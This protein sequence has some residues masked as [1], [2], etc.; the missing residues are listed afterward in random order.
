MPHSNDAGSVVCAVLIYY[1]KQ[2]MIL[3]SE[4]QGDN[5]GY[6][7]KTQTESKTT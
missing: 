6:A 4:E 5:I 3:E 2:R 1:F 7:L